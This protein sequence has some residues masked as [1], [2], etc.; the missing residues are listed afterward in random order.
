MENNFLFLEVIKNKISICLDHDINY[1]YHFDI[2]NVLKIKENDK[3]IE[4]FLNINRILLI[5]NI[6]ITNPY[7]TTDWDSIRSERRKISEAIYYGYL[8]DITRNI[9]RNNKLTELGL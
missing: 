9:D 2:G 8:L 4:T 5:G 3:T 7:F 6:E 1:Y